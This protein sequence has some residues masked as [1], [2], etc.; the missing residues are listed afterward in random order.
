MN[1]YTFADVVQFSL[2]DLWGRIIGILPDIIG[3]IIVLLLGLIVA[4]I[5]GGIVKKFFDIIFIISY[6]P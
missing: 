3:A 6:L 5:L 1:A 4:P 2:L